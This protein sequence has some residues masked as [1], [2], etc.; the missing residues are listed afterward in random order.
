M[1]QWELDVHCQVAAIA[2]FPD[3]IPVKSY[4]FDLC[5]DDQELDGV[6]QSCKTVF[7][8]ARKSF[9]YLHTEDNPTREYWHDNFDGTTSV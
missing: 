1:G 6:F 8:C 7:H 2:D 3:R 9:Q 4:V 5:D